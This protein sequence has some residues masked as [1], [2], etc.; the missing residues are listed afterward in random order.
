MRQLETFKNPNTVQL[1]PR[2]GARTVAKAS[3][4]ILE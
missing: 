1:K 2:S 3:N 4:A